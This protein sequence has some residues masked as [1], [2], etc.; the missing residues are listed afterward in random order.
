MAARVPCAVTLGVDSGQSHRPWRIAQVSDQPTPPSTSLHLPPPPT[1]AL[2][3]SLKPCGFTTQKV[4]FS[5]Y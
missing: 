3:L 5:S 4:F 1:P 2:Y